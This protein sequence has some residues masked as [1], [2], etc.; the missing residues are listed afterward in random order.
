GAEPAVARLR[1]AGRT[2]GGG[3]GVRAHRPHARCGPRAAVLAGGS[4]GLP[5]HSRTDGAGLDPVGPPEG[6]PAGRPAGA[7]DQGLGPRRR[8]RAGL[9]RRSSGGVL[10]PLFNTRII[11]VRHAAKRREESMPRYLIERDVSGWTA[12]EIDVAGLRAKM[13]APWFVG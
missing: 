8:A 9:R 11:D 13:C 6:E 12:E 5:R 1:R 7:A 10:A 4:G 3:R 2:P